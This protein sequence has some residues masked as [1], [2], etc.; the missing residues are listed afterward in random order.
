MLGGS[1]LSDKTTVCVEGNIGCGKTTMLKLFKD[2]VPGVEVLTEP[3]CKWQNVRG[4]NTLGLMYEDPHRWSFAF[5]SYLQLTMLQNHT[6]PS[7]QPLKLMERSLFSARHV[8]VENLYRSNKMSDAEYAIINEWFDWIF[9]N[10]NLNV[11]RIIYLRTSPQKC[12]ERIK[13]RCRSEENC[14]PLEYLQQ[15]HNLHEEWLMGGSKSNPNSNVVVVDADQPLEEM[16]EIY[17]K[18]DATLLHV[19]RII[20]V[21]S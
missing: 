8:F 5:Q 21:Q 16:E 2:Q 13:K 20:E 18:D 17:F 6:F 10:M 15:I 3:V 9:E 7:K 11:D 1:L 14:I 12:Y 4:H 19:E